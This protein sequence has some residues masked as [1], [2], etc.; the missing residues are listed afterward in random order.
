MGRTVNGFRTVLPL[1]PSPE[2]NL[3]TLD[4]ILRHA[5]SPDRLVVVGDP[6]SLRLLRDRHPGFGGDVVVL[7]EPADNPRPLRLLLDLAT[8]EDLLLV[9][10]G[11]Q[12]VP[13]FDLRLA[14][15][16][17]SSPSLGAVSPLCGV[18]PTSVPG[19]LLSASGDVV[20]LDRRLA[21]WSDTSVIDAP[22]LLPSCFMVRR[23]ACMGLD[24]EAF[25]DAPS[26]FA[27]IR[28]SGFVLGLVPHIVVGAAAGERWPTV[29]QTGSAHGPAGLGELVVRHFRRPLPIDSGID[30]RGRTRPRVLHVAHSLGGGLDHWVRLFASAAGGPES[31][32][33]RSV[34]LP[35]RFGTEL[36]LFDDPLDAR[37]RRIW[38]LTSPIAATA[39][40]HLEY[41]RIFEEIV[42]ELGIE[43]VVVSSLIGHSLDTLR[44][45]LAT[46]YVC[47][48]YYPFCPALHIHFGGICHRCPASRLERCRLENPL[49]DIFH[50][51][52][53]EEWLAL[54]HDFLA[55][56]RE[57]GVRVVAPSPSVA[58]NYRRLAPE[59]ADLPFQPIEHGSGAAD[60]LPVRARRR[61]RPST[62]GDD[63]RLR[64]VVLGRLSIGKGGDLFERLLPQ[65]GG[66]IEF[67]LVGCGARMAAR[68][69]RGV[70]VVAD[71]EPAELAGLLDR[72]EP[73]LAL[74]LSIVPET[75]SFTLSECFAAGIP[76]LATRIGSFEDRI[77]EG[78]TGFLV[79]PSE[80]SVAGCLRELS[81]DRERL[82]D[83]ERHLARLPLRTV[84]EM[85]D[86]YSRLLELP[87]FSRRAYFSRV[88]SGA[89]E[90]PPPA[91]ASWLPPRSPLGFRDFLAQMEKG[92]RHHIESSA[93]LR[94]WQRRLVGWAARLGFGVTR[95]LMRLF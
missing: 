65:L 46:A 2:R 74:L 12:A 1:G 9:A 4:S 69:P 22:D 61:T 10:P 39:N 45:G 23:Q 42:Q 15:S 66:E 59:L 20:D 90:Q 94:P 40:R 18:D 5:A 7:E 78:V 34:G 63:R 44:S 28:R 67:H 3:V 41:R 37:P 87:A 81:R 51:G 31:W 62:A 14:W 26:L 19:D 6:A 53:P 47:H 35:T 8:A 50:R 32:V 13:L 85:V 72:I 86:D 95:G 79:E 54:R 83:V 60:L 24:R 11:I 91:N 36:W 16:L 52:D 27:A 25:S 43:S 75:F 38:K 93:R 82:I 70:R 84:D 21:S 88:E 30:V 33:L 64:V 77:V 68:T 92:V 55:A 76:P 57:P 73:D 17:R 80:Q 71:Y 89:A 48:D 58:R 56:L 29:E 49:E